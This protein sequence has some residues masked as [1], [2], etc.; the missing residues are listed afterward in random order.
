MDSIPVIYWD[1]IMIIVAI[2][3]LILQILFSS[4]EKALVLHFKHPPSMRYAEY[5]TTGRVSSSPIGWR[6]SVTGYHCSPLIHRVPVDGFGQYA[7][8]LNQCSCH[9]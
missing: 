9:G 1:L 3:F 7:T 8:N 6:E 2:T 5:S 4:E